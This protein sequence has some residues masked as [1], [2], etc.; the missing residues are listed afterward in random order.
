MAFGEGGKVM[1]MDHA[2]S[3]GWPTEVMAPFFMPKGVNGVAYDPFAISGANHWYSVGA[4]RVRAVSND[5]ANATFRPGWLRSVG[6]GWTNWA[7]ESFMDEAAHSVGKDPV[8]FRLELLDAAG[9]NSGVAA[10]RAR[11]RRQAAARRGARALAEKAG[12]GEPLPANTGLG[13]GDHLR[14]GA[15]H[16]D[17]GRLRGPGPRRSGD[18]QGEGREADPGGRRRHA[19]SARTARCAQVEGARALGHEP[20]AV[21]GH[22]VQGRAGEGHQPRQPTPRCGWPTCRRSRSIFVES[23]EVAGGPGR[24]GDDGGRAR[25]SPTPS[26]TRSGSRVRD[27][28]IRAAD[29]LAG[30][31]S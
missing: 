12:W 4:Q 5:L 1:A 29:V 20:G 17:L 24:A 19:S 8:A 16:A 11:R 26:S 9:R 14:P 7:V 10:G 21:R 15:R 6:P 30:L 2:A 31:K 28:P 18:R 22:R 23:T 25:P 3:A 27:L 13:H